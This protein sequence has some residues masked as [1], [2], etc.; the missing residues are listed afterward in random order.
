MAELA[1]G[2]IDDGASAVRIPEHAKKELEADLD[3]GL[4]CRGFARLGA[5]AADFLDEAY[6]EDGGR[7][8]VGES[9]T[10]ARKRIG[11]R[12]AKPAR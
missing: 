1:H 6:R 3:C 11:P 7:A 10:S 8:R 4:L 12:P 9:P 5:S 2:A